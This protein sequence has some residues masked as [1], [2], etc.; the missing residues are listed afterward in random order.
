MFYVLGD[1]SL[2]SINCPTSFQKNP[3]VFAYCKPM[4][5]KL[6][7]PS[8][9]CVRKKTRLMLGTVNEERK[10]CHG[11]LVE[12]S[13]IFWCSL[14]MSPPKHRTEKPQWIPLVVH[15][16]FFDFWLN[17]PICWK[18][19]VVCLGSWR[20]VKYRAY[21]SLLLKKVHGPSR[22]LLTQQMFRTLSLVT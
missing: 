7:W 11:S 1:G 10:W 21:F 15:L 8:P 14:K 9:N 3:S 5:V 20:A 4:A 18:N 22:S 2:C 12:G 17:Q 6:I 19:F 16:A 13:H